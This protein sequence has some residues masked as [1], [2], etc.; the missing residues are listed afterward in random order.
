MRAPFSCFKAEL[1]SSLPVWCRIFTS[2][3]PADPTKYP[4]M[5]IDV[6]AFGAMS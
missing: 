6:L 3:C 5:Q 2:G 4:L 1:I